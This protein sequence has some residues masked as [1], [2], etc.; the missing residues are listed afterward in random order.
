MRREQ[1]QSQQG[2][3]IPS[4]DLLPRRHF[5]GAGVAAII[6]HILLPEAGQAP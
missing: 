3:E 2:A 6:Q 1:R 4:F 5:A